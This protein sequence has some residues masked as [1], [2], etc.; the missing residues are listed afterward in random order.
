[1]A[2]AQP[3]RGLRY[4]LEKTEDLSS[5]I[6][7]PYDVIS[8]EQQTAYYERNPHNLIRLEL[9]REFPEDTDQNSRYTRAAA[10]LE[11]WLREGV[12]VREKAPAYYLTEHRFLHRGNE[13]SYWG[14]IAA[15]RLEEFDA[16]TIR[17]TEIT[18]AAPIEDRLNLL[19]SCRVNL[20]PIMGT[21]IQ[22]EGDLL[23]LLPEIDL[24]NPDMSATND[25][26]VTFNLWVIDEERRAK[27]LTDFFADKFIYI[28]DGHHRYT[29]ALTY[30]KEQT[31][32]AID[33]DDSRNFVMMT[34]ISSNDR[35]LTMLP[36]HRLVR[37]LQPEQLVK[38]KE[39]LP[40]YFQIQELTA[41]PN[42]AEK[43]QVWMNSL[44][45]AGKAG[46]AFGIYGLEADRY[47]LLVPHDVA[48]MHNTLPLE[49][50]LS[51]RKLDV[52]L[53]HGIIL[54]GILGLDTPE[55]QKE[56]LEYSPDEE[57]V[58]Q[59]VESG[60]AQLA[61]FL[62][63]AQ[64]SRVM[65]VADDG[66]RMPQKSTYFYPKTTAGLVMNPLF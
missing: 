11:D 52:S 5:V 17:A 21:F 55:K 43:L 18:M 46:T 24:A 35:G 9:G 29:T 7:P 37:G 26:G 44:V 56:C 28:A 23:T 64:I 10:T 2:D 6:T 39:R 58:L 49:H 15:V 12:L 32:L 3:F 63:A 54:Q 57:L 61:V 31:D 34:L 65:A 51:W 1:M 41:P 4:N 42:P 8:D 60:E 62:N 14:L 27:E 48:A 53:L 47:L 13:M 25:F 59:K 16:G 22:K 30:Q 33:S 19:R 66:D 20:S 38:L 50:P 36:T 40:E 45:E